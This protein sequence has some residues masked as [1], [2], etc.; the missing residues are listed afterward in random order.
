MAE[1]CGGGK[2]VRTSHLEAGER[3]DSSYH[4]KI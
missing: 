3:G 1:E 4:E 2:H